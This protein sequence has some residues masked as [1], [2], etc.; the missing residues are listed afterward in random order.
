MI[1]GIVIKLNNRSVP[2]QVVTLIT[3]CCLLV[4]PKSALASSIKCW[5]NKQNV[6]ECGFQ[7]P[8]EYAR[9]RIEILNNRGMVVRVIQAAKTKAQLKQDA[10]LAALRAQQER[11]AEK[12]RLLLKTYTTERDLIIARDNKITAIES[13]VEITESNNLNI[14]KSLE[15]LQERAANYERSGEAPPKEILAIM[16]KSKNKI[17]D[18]LKFI[19][20]KRNKQSE[21]RKIYAGYLKRFKELKG[22]PGKEILAPSNNQF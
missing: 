3:L 20:A 19:E 11:Q 13:L 12:D 22:S 5:V 16:K 6:R 9:Q 7:V 15:S 8:V 10:R 1:I 21:I 18:N 2:I 14:G 17:A 4:I